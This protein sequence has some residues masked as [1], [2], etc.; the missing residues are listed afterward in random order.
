MT[1]PIRWWL[2]KLVHFY[3]W[4]TRCRRPNPKPM[5]EPRW[6]CGHLKQIDA[7]RCTDMFCT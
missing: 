5:K 3:L 7:K 1:N 4:W 6:P 2:T